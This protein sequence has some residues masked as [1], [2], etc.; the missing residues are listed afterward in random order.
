VVP[1][2]DLC[3]QVKLYV[4]DDHLVLA[5]GTLEN[6][7]IIRGLPEHGLHFTNVGDALY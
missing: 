1:I 7:S 5:L 2:R 6:F 4:R 3:P